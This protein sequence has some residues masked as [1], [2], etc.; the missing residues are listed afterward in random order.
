MCEQGSNWKDVVLRYE[1]LVLP[2]VEAKAECTV[3]FE[4]LRII[5]VMC[6]R[7][8]TELTKQDVLRT[9]FATFVFCRLV[10]HLVHVGS[11]PQRCINLYFI[12]MSIHLP[13]TMGLDRTKGEVVPSEHQTEFPESRWSWLRSAAPSAAPHPSAHTAWPAERSSIAATTTVGGGSC[14]R[15]SW[16]TRRTSPT[17]RTS[18]STTI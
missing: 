14:S 5:M 8:R 3:L 6:S 17:C 18:A 12:W 7:T 16:M 13:Y 4:M 11:F 10:E 2:S 15:R 9:C 1:E